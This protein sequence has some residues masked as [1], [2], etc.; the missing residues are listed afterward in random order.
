MI[1]AG[2]AGHGSIGMVFRGVGKLRRTEQCSFIFSA[3]CC[4]QHFYHLNSILMISKCILY[5][6]TYYY[7]SIIIEHIFV[8]LIEK[9]TV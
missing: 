5:V 9:Y 3:E 8:L 4:Q 2:L 6:Q 7:V 1:L